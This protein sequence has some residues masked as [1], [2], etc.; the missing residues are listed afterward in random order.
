MKENEVV[1]IGKNT[2]S[3]IGSVLDQFETKKFMLVCGSSFDKQE[4]KTYFDVLSVPSVR[5]SDFNSNPLYEDVCKGVDIFNSEE[6]DCLVVV[7]GGSAIDVAKCIKLFCKMD[8]E[9]NYL[10]QEYIGSQIPLIAIPTTAGTGSESTKYAAIYYKGIKQSISHDSIVPNVAIID[11]S[12]LIRL[13]EYHKKCAMLDALCQ[14]IES[15]WSV[16]STDESEKFARESIELIAI[17]WREYMAGNEK[18][19][20]KIMLAANLAGRAINITQT[21]A[22]HAMSYSLT[23][24]YKLPHGNAVALCLPL[25]WKYMVSNLSNCIDPRGVE[26]LKTVF[27]KIAKAFGVDNVVDAIRLF[28][29]LMTELKIS[30]PETHNAADIE[31]LT[32]SVSQVRLKNNPVMLSEEVLHEMYTKIVRITK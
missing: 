29:T 15:F 2:I 27:K 7:G 16:N 17:N 1:M 6:C 24:M 26:Y 22:A 28:E 14:G 20:E 12:T 13:P 18:A 19:A 31:V 21:T 23:S 30:F 9:Q 10:V 3:Q 5:F 25:I 4:F 11:S 8:R 32:A